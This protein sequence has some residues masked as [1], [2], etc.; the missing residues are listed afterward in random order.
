MD[1]GEEDLMKEKKA[2]AF[3]QGV[4]VL[5]ALAILTAVEYW[6][7]TASGSLVFLSII[8]LAKGGLILNYFMHM[9]SLWG[10]ETH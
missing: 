7:S 5:V 4:M 1:R 2:A 10:E 9:G 6:I 8:A 3:R